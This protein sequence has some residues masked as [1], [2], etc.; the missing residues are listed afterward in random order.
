MERIF[1]RF[2]VVTVKVEALATIIFENNLWTH[3]GDK[4]RET[5]LNQFFLP[6]SLVN[7]PQNLGMG[8]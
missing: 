7:T 5:V 2:L 4:I 1:I 8:F 3:S 6:G